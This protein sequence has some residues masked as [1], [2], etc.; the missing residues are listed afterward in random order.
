MGAPVV[1]ILHEEEALVGAAELVDS[2]MR[3]A[4]W[5]G[6]PADEQGEEAQAG[7]INWAALEEEWKTI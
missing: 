3:V 7:V 2:H 4:A 5:P 1:E 6:P